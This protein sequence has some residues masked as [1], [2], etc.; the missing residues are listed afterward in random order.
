LLGT[1]MDMPEEEVVEDAIGY[2]KKIGACKAES[3]CG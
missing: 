3:I 2:L 1:C